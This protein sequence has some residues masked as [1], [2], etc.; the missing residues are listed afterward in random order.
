MKL[1]KQRLVEYDKAKGFAIFLVV[2]GHLVATDAPEN[3]H[4][5]SQLKDIIYSFH[6]PFFMFLSGFML[7]YSLPEIK[8]WED[9]KRLIRK[10]SK[11]LVPPFLFF[12][13]LI[14]SGKLLASKYVAVD[15]PVQDLS[16]FFDIFLTPYYSYSAYL[17]Y[18]Y[19]LLEYYLLFPALCYFLKNR[20][21][22]FLVPAFILQFI[23]PYMEAYFALDLF[24]KYIFV[25]T[26]G[27]VFAKN[28]QQF[29]NSLRSW[30]FA[31]ISL[32]AVALILRTQILIPDLI[33][34]LL[35]IPALYSLLS[36]SLGDRGTSTSGL[37]AIIGT[38]AF[39]IY[40]MNTIAIGF[41]KGLLTQF[42]SWEG[43]HFYWITF[44]MLIAGLGLPLLAKNL[45][46]RKVR[47]LD[48]FTG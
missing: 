5:M 7:F 44:L 17:W 37:W 2:L 4:W 15:N 13:I 41:T 21:E 39:P 47:L 20:I 27:G 14:F 22:H 46:F 12:A 32:F 24:F 34:G 43:M 11:R 19:V 1:Q 8:K 29:M 10:K 31:F 48:I 26:V 28:Y 25:F 9:Y 36:F 40:L 42:F 33:M 38:Y 18:I 35:S 23:A 3:H 16:G 45:I 30:G 6:M